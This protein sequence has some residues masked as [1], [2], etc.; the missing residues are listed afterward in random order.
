MEALIQGGL[1]LHLFMFVGV[2]TLVHRSQERPCHIRFH[3]CTIMQYYT[4]TSWW[5]LNGMMISFD[6]DEEPIRE[7]LTKS[8]WSM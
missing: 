8:R 2:G 5:W 6:D 4:L 7:V 3:L 1:H